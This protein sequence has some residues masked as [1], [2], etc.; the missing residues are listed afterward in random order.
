MFMRSFIRLY[1][2]LSDISRVLF[3]L[4]ISFTLSLIIMSLFCFV[5]ADF[6]ECYYD[7]K[8]LSAELIIVLRSSFFML[9]AGVVLTN[10]MENN[11]SDV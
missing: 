8:V 4:L 7:M 6:S 3:Q 9:S 11:K 5:F 10:Y 2:S 1:H